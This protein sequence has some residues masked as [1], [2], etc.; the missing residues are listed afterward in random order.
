VQISRQSVGAG[1]ALAQHFAAS[2]Q[3]A[4][5]QIVK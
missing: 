4:L 1:L 2:G 3:T 5:G